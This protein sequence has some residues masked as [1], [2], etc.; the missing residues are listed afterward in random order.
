MNETDYE[1]VVVPQ[2]NSIDPYLAKCKTF[3]VL[4]TYTD[5]PAGGRWWHFW[6]R[7]PE[8]VTRTGHIA[9][10]SQLSEAYSSKR[11]LNF[12]WMGPGFAQVD[13]SNPCIVRSRALEIVR[14][15]DVNAVVS[16]H[17]AV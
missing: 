11:P 10:L 9:A 3:T 4:G 8:A 1:L 7:F 15:K 5:R 6:S 2:P 12:G 17:D 16:Y 14:E 13:S